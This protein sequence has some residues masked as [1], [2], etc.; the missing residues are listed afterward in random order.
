MSM[1]C[2]ITMQAE[3]LPTEMQKVLLK[4]YVWHV[5]H[6]IFPRYVDD[7][8]VSGFQLFLAMS[9]DARSKRTDKACYRETRYLKPDVAG[10][11]G[12]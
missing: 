11:R 12:Y 8:A 6:T 2:H 10:G 1:A 5:R 4:H 3:T 9:K 7:S